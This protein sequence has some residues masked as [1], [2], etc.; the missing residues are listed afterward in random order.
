MHIFTSCAKFKRNSMKKQYKKLEHGIRKIIGEPWT[1]F[2]G[3][4][5]LIS[6]LATVYIAIVSINDSKLRYEEVLYALLATICVLTI[7]LVRQT[8]KYGELAD[9]FS[10]TSQIQDDYFNLTALIQTQAETTHNV[11]H[12]FRS[13]IFELDI[14]IEKFYKNEVVSE[15]EVK[16]IE[17]INFN[18]LI[19]L[20]TSLQ[21]Y[22]SIHTDDNC[23]I[24]IKI[25]NNDNT[26]VKT[27][28]R[29]PVN[30]K[31]R[32]QSEL[33]YNISEYKVIQNS[34]FV[35]ILDENNT[36]TYY[37]N[38]DLN[39][40]KKYYKNSNPD[41]F[42]HYNATFVTPIS[43]VESGKPEKRN[44]LGFLTLDNKQGYLIDN[45]TLEL[46]FAMSDLLYT[47][48]HKCKTFYT[49]TALNNLNNKMQDEFNWN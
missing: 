48:V 5:T 29:D 4:I 17:E 25:L 46:M 23:S 20:T 16:F 24:T 30:L 18:F 28:F 7:S 33:K 43:I 38:N 8:V 31:K 40:D 13:F 34:A 22:F 15:E 47:Y 44:I 21:N 32:R 39:K 11:N 42:N 3:F 35:T 6:L 14:L 2:Y 12:Y 49:F 1:H 10:Q 37:A 27:L 26:K 45:I 36:D 19:M 9:D 41:W